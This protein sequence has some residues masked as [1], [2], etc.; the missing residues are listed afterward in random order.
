MKRIIS[1]LLSVMMLIGML[2]SFSGIAFASDAVTAF[3]DTYQAKYQDKFNKAAVIDNGALLVDSNI[4]ADEKTAGTITRTWD[5]IDFTFTYGTNAFSSFTDAYAYAKAEAIERPAIIVTGWGSTTTVTISMASDVYA[6]NWDTVPMNEMSDDFDAIASNGADW[7]AN[8]DFAANELKI[9]TITVNGDVQGSASI[10]GFTLTKFI[11]HDNKRTATSTKFEFLIKNSKMSGVSTTGN[12]LKGSGNTSTKNEDKI[13]FKNFWLDTIGGTSTS[14]S[15]FF[16]DNTRHSSHIEFDGLY[17]DMSKATF[18]K[19]NDHLKA[20]AENTSVTFKNSNLRKSANSGNPYW[21]FAQVNTDAVTEYTRTLTFENNVMYNWNNANSS[22]INNLGLGTYKSPNVIVVKDNYVINTNAALKLLNAANNATV[23]GN[24]LLGVTDQTITNGSASG[25]FLVTSVLASPDAY[26]TATGVPYSASTIFYIDYDMTMLDAAFPLVEGSVTIGGVSAIVNN[27]ASTIDFAAGENAVTKADIV[28]YKEYNDHIESVLGDFKG[29]FVKPTVTIET[30]SGDAVESIDTTTPGSYTVTLAYGDYMSKKYDVSVSDSAYPDTKEYTALVTE[31]SSTYANTMVVNKKWT[32]AQLVE[33][34]ELTYWFRGKT[35]TETYDASRHFNT[36][37]NAQTAFQANLTGTDLATARPNYIMLGEFKEVIDIKYSA[38]LYGANAG[39]SPNDPDFEPNTA[40]PDATWG[41]NPDW[42]TENETI[43]AYIA[44]KGFMW[45]HTTAQEKTISDAGGIATVNIDGFSYKKGTSSKVPNDVIWYINTGSYRITYTTNIKN[46]IL[47]SR[48]GIVAL[49]DKSNNFYDL[50]MQNVRAE[51]TQYLFFW[52]YLRNV[53]VDR[54][55]FDSMASTVTAMLWEPTDTSLVVNGV[56][57]YNSYLSHGNGGNRNVSW[58]FTN[59][60]FSNNLSTNENYLARFVDNCYHSE[61]KFTFENNLFKNASTASDGMIKFGAYPNASNP[62]PQIVFKNNTI[63][64]SKGTKDSVIAADSS[65]LMAAYDLEFTGNRVI[66]FKA[67]FP[68]FT[69]EMDSFVANGNWNV[70]KNYF[71]ATYSSEND[72]T[73]KIGYWHEDTAITSLPYDIYTSTWYSDY[74][75][76]KVIKPLKLGDPAF[77]DSVLTYD[78]NYDKK[79]VFASIENGVDITNLSFTSN[80]GTVK[81]YSDAELTTEVTSVTSEQLSAVDGI[82]TLY[83]VITDADQT[84]TY[85]FILSKVIYDD[86]STWTDTTGTVKSGFGVLLPDGATTQ[87]G[88]YVI[89]W[90]G[91]NYTVG[92]ENAFTTVADAI[93]AGKT[94]LIMPTGKYANVEISGAI[95]LYGNQYGKNP[96]V[97]GEDR[98]DDWTLNPDWSENKTTV[99]QFT[100][101]A[102]ANGATI[103]VDGV[104][105]TNRILDTAR[106][107]FDGATSITFKNILLSKDTATNRYIVNLANANTNSSETTYVNKDSF[108]F[109]D[110]RLNFDATDT[111]IRFFNAYTGANL[112]VEGTYFGK[113]FPFVGFLQQPSTTADASVNFV[114][115]Y[116]EKYRDG[117]E[118]DYTALQIKGVAPHKDA[119]VSDGKNVLNVTGN[120]FK[121]ILVSS[122]TTKYGAFQFFEGGFDEVNIKNNTVI[123]SSNNYYDFVNAAVHRSEFASD[124][125]DYSALVNITGNRLIGVTYSTAPKGNENASANYHAYYTADFKTNTDGE[126]LVDALEGTDYYL[127]YAKTVLASDLYL[128]ASQVTQVNNDGKKASIIVADV[129][130]YTPAFTTENGDITFT[131]YNEKDCRT[132]VTKFESGRSY[133]LK[134]TKNDISVVYEL[135][136]SEGNPDAPEYA[137]D[138]YLL[139][140]RVGKMPVGAKFTETYKDA[141]YIFTVGKNAFASVSQITYAHAKAGKTTTPEIIM[142]NGPHKGGYKVTGDINVVGDNAILKAD[143]DISSVKIATIGDSVTEGSGYNNGYP[144][145]K[146]YP[147]HLQVML[148]ETYG[149]GNYTVKNF[150]KENATATPVNVTTRV[151][152]GG[153]RNQYIRGSWYYSLRDYNPDVV[154]IMLGYNDSAPAVFKGSNVY[155]QCIRD[156]IDGARSTGSHP[157]IVFSG[158]HYTYAGNAREN[159]I[160]SVITSTQ[161]RLAEEYGAIFVDN[162]DVIKNPETGTHYASQ[163]AAVA[164]NYYSDGVHL[165]SPGYEVLANS[166]KTQTEVLYSASRNV[167]K[168]AVTVD[169]SVEV[170][171]EKVIKVA[172]IGDDLSYGAL[173]YSGYHKYLQSLLGTGYEVRNYAEPKSTVVDGSTSFKTYDSSY[174]DIADYPSSKAWAPD[175]AIFSFGKNDTAGDDF[176]TAYVNLIKEYEA[177]GTEIYISTVL[178]NAVNANIREIA[179]EN[180][181]TLIDLYASASGW[182]ASMFTD[183][184]KVLFSDSGNAEVA[185]IMNAAFTSP[186]FATRDDSNDVIKNTA[187]AVI[188]SVSGSTDGTLVTASWQ[189][190]DYNF[191]VGKNAFATVADALAKT[192]ASQVIIPAN[193][194]ATAVSI[195]RSVTIYGENY[196]VMPWVV[197]GENVVKNTKWGKFGV[198]NVSNITI[199]ASAAGATIKV[200]GVDITGRFNDTKRAVSN[201][202]TDITLENTILYKNTSSSTREFDLRNPNNKNTDTAYTNIDAFTIKNM[203]FVNNAPH[204]DG[205]FFQEGQPAYFTIDGFGCNDNMQTFGFPKWWPGVKEGEMKL[206]NSYIKSNLATSSK[207]DPLVYFS[208]HTSSTY[209]S[210][211]RGSMPLK[212]TVSNNTLVDCLSPVTTVSSA[213]GST[214]GVIEI[215]P[216]AYKQIDITNNTFISPNDDSTK[217]ISWNSNAAIATNDKDFS[218]NITFTKNRV[219]GYLASV[220]VNDL[221][222]IDLSGNFFETALD[223]YKLGAPGDTPADTDADTYIDYEL[224]IKRSDMIPQSESLGLKAL[225][226]ID[227]VYGYSAGNVTSFDFANSHGVTYKVYSDKECTTEITSLDVTVG[228][229][230]K[231]YLKATKGDISLVYTFIVM[232]V[233]DMTDVANAKTSIDGIDDAALYYPS[234]YAQPN[235]IEVVTYYDG[236]PIKFTTGK[237]VVSSQAQFGMFGDN[238]IIPDHITDVTFEILTKVNL[239]SAN[240]IT[241]N[242]TSRK[243]KIACVGDSITEG[244]T[245]EQTF[246]GEFGYPAM[247]QQYLGTTDFEVENFGQSGRTATSTAP[248]KNGEERSFKL[249]SK[250]YGLS[251]SYEGDVVIIGLGTNDVNWAFWTSNDRFIQSYVE[252]IRDYQALES[253]PA[254]YLTTAT[255]R[256]DGTTLI[257]ARVAENL[258][259]IQRVVADIT[260]AQVIDN[261]TLMSDMFSSAGTEYS[262]DKIHPNKAGYALY[263]QRVTNEFSKTYTGATCQVVNLNNEEALNTHAVNVVEGKDN[264]CTED[265]YTSYKTCDNCDYVGGK[266]IIPASHT[267]VKIPQK[268]ATATENGYKEHYMC[269]ICGEYFEDEAAT[270]PIADI[271][272]WKSGDGKLEIAGVAQNEQTGEVY[273]S[274]ID[275]LNDAKPGET[276][277]LTADAEGEY[278]VVTPGVTLDLNGHKL[279]TDYFVALKDSAIIDTSCVEDRVVNETYGIKGATK[280]GGLYVEKGNTMMLYSGVR[281]EENKKNTTYMPIYDNENGCY[282]FIHTEM[283]DNQFTVNG[284]NFTFMPII[285]ANAEERH[286]IQ[287]DLLATD[288]VTESGLKLKVRVTWVTDGYEASQ[289]FSMK[290]EMTKNF[291]AGFGYINGDKFVNNYKSKNAASFTGAALKQA[292]YVYISA[293][294]VSETGAELESIV[295]EVDT[296]TLN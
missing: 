169:E 259:H 112:T 295:T 162:S 242:L 83:V 32:A 287:K 116:F 79:T 261:Y 257:T 147:Q 38:N 49:E 63:Y 140:D 26:A 171:T 288:N 93:A 179:A 289:D 127:D 281:D 265:G 276:L 13:T 19:T 88:K 108:A 43:I 12:I 119:V 139:S 282:R 236:M 64:D 149:E 204:S 31:G 103:V 65:T 239:F 52:R 118:I 233:K 144:D 200:M 67:P 164:S 253:K 155:E 184:S 104:E 218:D 243:V 80:Y 187:V 228:S 237:N 220:H 177:L 211:E 145:G 248:L 143:F 199:D 5:G 117:T 71:S 209:T 72:T 98:V 262:N 157:Q 113:N 129:D 101:T 216:G 213:C 153:S 165:R 4:T 201:E 224:T 85:K 198:S 270:K 181:W 41:M 23:T 81:V 102:D 227:T 11:Q 244:S 124:D 91:A 7:T 53:T 151:N 111:N 135:Y 192:D 8:P 142:A 45:R 22:V 17:V 87:V 241:T 238:I 73:G 16:G 273:A 284:G 14:G 126:H 75:M 277:T 202:K 82:M 221:T 296:S 121:D 107:A 208:G 223:D 226:P 133:Y 158:T 99:A 222:T 268:D 231:A 280:T 35:Y 125:V 78:V 6:P 60:M 180:G 275:A 178:N 245:T 203:F 286:G 234:L 194:T 70:D 212:V 56:Q 271:D 217:I 167:S 159:L 251:I 278:T 30:L 150:G 10:H 58:T 156:I 196:D 293:I 138:K 76:T 205:V 252:L 250:Q 114:D 272:A 96:N 68:A 51:Q 255:A 206:T 175:V 136:V 258:R 188:P 148:D 130:A 105:L 137:E 260:G 9:G 69:A 115:N 249:S 269:E 191:V 173:S 28:N 176:K 44:T 21:N 62:T 122:S 230:S 66:G 161:K 42:N 1:M 186:S 40:A 283:R 20:Y 274:V 264:T 279:T 25:N 123:S 27:E 95:E 254:I 174:G 120:V 235:G 207:Y 285:G 190:K 256:Y 106:T 134:A 263:A 3:A 189:N 185:E 34:T 168:T 89:V 84:E 267:I 57:T 94:Q 39:I 15:R 166:I 232:G 266:E 182:D 197:D 92:P 24:V 128:K 37:A 36:F 291:V 215:Y 246:R 61:I 193:E 132:V 146:T 294:V 152:Y 210:E 290:D 47:Q 54:C 59:S 195:S 229:A 97:I 141:V 2:N 172:A 86:V 109:V 46:S 240:E 50:N 154:V 183:T 90:Q 55:L 170:E 33:G 29:S 225:M 100:V 163:S 48:Y 77:K 160:A 110:S 292:D 18:L 247:M 131:A 214:L 74:K 219:I